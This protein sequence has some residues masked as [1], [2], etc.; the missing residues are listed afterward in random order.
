MWETGLL[1]LLLSV[2]HF[3]VYPALNFFSTYVSGIGSSICGTV[4]FPLHLHR[5]SFNEHLLSICCM[6][7]TI[8]YL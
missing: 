7:A 1:P 4:W 5:F 2:P 8:P 6:L 3:W